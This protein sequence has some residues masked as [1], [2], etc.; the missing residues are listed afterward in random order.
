MSSL[1]RSIGKGVGKGEGGLE[2]KGRAVDTRQGTRV[3][4]GFA[5]M[6]KTSAFQVSRV[7]FSTF[8]TQACA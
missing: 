1:L 7:F 4:G 8:D 2:R 3:D 6:S 5:T